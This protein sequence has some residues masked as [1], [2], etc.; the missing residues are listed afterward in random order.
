[1]KKGRLMGQLKIF[2]RTLNFMSKR[3]FTQAF[4]A[5]NAVIEK[6]GKFLIVQ[7]GKNKNVYR[8]LWALPGGWIEAENDDP[9]NAVIR[10]VKEETGLDFTPEGILGIY[11]FENQK[12]K[13]IVDGVPHPIK[14]VFY[15][16]ATGN[17]DPILKKEISAA[18]W[19][20]KEDFPEINWR[21]PFDTEIFKTYLAGAKYPLSMIHHRVQK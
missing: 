2:L 3:V 9:I 13:G 18:K 11:S 8:G 17:V 1:M 20:R 21:T 14:I 7:Q 10:E 12:L 16:R 5:V 6:D 15:G 19:V 4:P